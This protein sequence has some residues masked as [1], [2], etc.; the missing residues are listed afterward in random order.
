MTENSYLWSYL[1]CPYGFDFPLKLQFS[2][3]IVNGW[4]SSFRIGGF[5]YLMWRCYWAESKGFDGSPF[6][7]TMLLLVYVW[8]TGRIFISRDVRWNKVLIFH[9]HSVFEAQVYYGTFVDVACFEWT[10]WVIS[11]RFLYLIWFEFA[12]LVLSSKTLN[13]IRSR[14]LI[15]MMLFWFSS[16]DAT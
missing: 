13:W 10:I 6:V 12:S 8:S 3:S 7:L 15:V 4:R 1:R 14:S 11:I 5:L 2:C 9:W 16:L